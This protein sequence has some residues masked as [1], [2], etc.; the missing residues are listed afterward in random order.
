[1]VQDFGS[2]QGHFHSLSI[3][4]CIPHFK[5]VCQIQLR[6]SI[7][8]WEEDSSYL[9]FFGFVNS[10]FIIM[11]IL[12]NISYIFSVH[13]RVKPKLYKQFNICLCFSMEKMMVLGDHCN[14]WHNIVQWRNREKEYNL[15][16]LISPHV[17]WL[18]HFA[19]LLKEFYLN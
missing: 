9:E 3:V 6:S 18:K 7:I 11:T 10:K 4:K 1:M 13:G 8:H 19:V 15:F 2:H 16:S 14:I 5:I 12:Y 17:T